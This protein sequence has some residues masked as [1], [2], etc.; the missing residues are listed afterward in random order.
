MS[1]DAEIVFITGHSCPGCQAELDL[2][3]T[4]PGSWLRCPR[5]GRPSLPPAEDL[6]RGPIGASGHRFIEVG[7]ST[8]RRHAPNLMGI[9]KLAA[10]G[11]LAVCVVID[12]LVRVTGGDENT[13]MLAD[14]AAFVCFAICVMLVIRSMVR[15]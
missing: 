3:G 8:A 11:L 10:P 6:A 14:V 1:T 4:D 2:A 7:A 5:C 12:V 13:R 9:A 15:A